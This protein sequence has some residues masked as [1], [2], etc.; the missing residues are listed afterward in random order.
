MDPNV[1]PARRSARLFSLPL[2]PSL[3]FGLALATP[4]ATQDAVADPGL[5]AAIVAALETPAAEEPG[6]L[7]IRYAVEDG[8]GVRVTEVLDGTPA[9]RAGFQ[10]G[11]LIVS[12]GDRTV[13]SDAPL[14]AV[15]GELGAG[16]EVHFG[17]L[18][19]EETVHLTATL[20]TREDPSGEDGEHADD[21][22]AEHAEQGEHGEH[23][24]AAASAERDAL[25]EAMRTLEA[26][27]GRAPA[28]AE[29]QHAASDEPGF[30]GVYPSST[31]DGVRIDS[32]VEGGAAAVGGLRAGDV[33]LTLDGERLANED[34]LRDA[35]AAR[36]RGT[37]ITLGIQR[38]GQRDTVVLALGGRDADDSTAADTQEQESADVRRQIENELRGLAGTD[39]WSG[40]Q[41]QREP[42]GDAWSDAPARQDA[43]AE[44]LRQAL[45]NLRN[46][47]TDA[48]GR[49]QSALDAR[50]E[51]RAAAE[52]MRREIETGMRA[53]QD[54]VEGARP[55]LGVMLD[56]TTVTSTIEGTGARAAGVQAGETITSLGGEAVRSL[57]DL[58]QLLGAR[59]PGER[60]QVGL[61]GEEG[62]RT[63]EVLLGAQPADP[64]EPAEAPAV[65]DGWV[66]ESPDDAEYGALL[67][68]LRTL[69]ADGQE[70]G[71]R[72]RA[73][74]GAA[75]SRPF[76]GVML[77]GT[78]VTS[79][80]EGTGAR[81]A[82]VQ[83]GESITSL[84]GEAVRSLGDL[85]Q[86][87]G[88]RRPGERVQLGLRGEGGERT[89]EVRLGTPPDEAAAAPEPVEIW[90]ESEPM[91]EDPEPIEVQEELESLREALRELPSDQRGY[92]GVGL[93]EEDGQI[94]I[95]QVLPGSPAEAAGLEPG[96]RIVRVR[97]SAIH[98]LGDLRTALAEL[99]V[100]RDFDLQ[101]E[102]DGQRFAARAELAP[103]PDAEAAEPEPRDQLERE[104]RREAEGLRR[105]AE[106]A[107]RAA[108]RGAREAAR[109]A[110]R[111]AREAREGAERRSEE[112]AR[113]R[114]EAERLLERFEQRRERE[115]RAMEKQIEQRMQQL[116][117]SLEQREQA[118]QRELEAIRRR[119]GD[120]AG[121][122]TER[123]Q[124][125]LRRWRQES[126]REL[127]RRAR[128]VRD[129]AQR[130][131]GERRA[132]RSSSELRLDPERWGDL[133]EQ[134]LEVLERHEGD[135]RFV[136]VQVNGETAARLEV[137]GREPMELIEIDGNA[138]RFR[139]EV[140]AQAPRVQEVR[141]A[142]QALRSEVESLRAEVRTLRTKLKR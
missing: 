122:R 68:E 109:A 38:G 33:I 25:L 17:V 31:D 78:T 85:Q 26:E 4:L 61:R 28:G 27:I 117:R 56:G 54:S 49:Q 101:I 95:E 73:Q 64:G 121:P 72:A 116:R 141:A 112:N 97:E 135:Q 42:S 138:L 118:L 46:A 63:I 7:G 80:I 44:A 50:D 75:G 43:E 102:R 34:A 12:V 76:L 128:E 133:E 88:S 93:S 32:L 91:E 62:A 53:L 127:D 110:E 58:Q 104:L 107:A 21:E 82:G 111:E 45:N 137:E 16:Q 57:D 79:T 131:E 126:E 90:V 134:R 86:L 66:L 132:E 13:D 5:E 39:G 94:R 81:S 1:V 52:A 136:E 130:L 36:T 77:D 3:L 47:R 29:K 103:R 124:E 125:E 51:A 41:T 87:L 71:E 19:G 22:H 2:A 15:L 140:E 114:A 96:D 113:E 18:R 92:L 14:L 65:A 84:D 123:M 8:Q 10:G 89:L 74:A 30:L 55:F 120:D 69:G 98:T 59:L 6:Y 100:H 24:E 99:P 142:M 83:A 106:G 115:L 119:L 37:K 129:R 23:S 70:A 35:I 105:E 9:D 108:E 60:V 67:R 139:T 48:G 40:G 11:D 20:A